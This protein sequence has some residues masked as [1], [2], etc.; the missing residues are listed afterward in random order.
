MFLRA[1][2]GGGGRTVGCGAG[3]G[4]EAAERGQNERAPD[5]V[6]EP[7]DVEEGVGWEG[8]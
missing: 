3:V 8:G 5:G 1:E 2:A 7:G 4:E 6:E